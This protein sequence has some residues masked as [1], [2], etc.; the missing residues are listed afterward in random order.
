MSATYRTEV[1]RMVDATP[2]TVYAILRDYRDGHPSIL[3]KPEFQAL[4]VE[5]GGVGA[6]TLIRVDMKVG[7]RRQTFRMRVEEPEPGRILT[8]TDL[9]TGTF[10]RFTVLPLDGGKRARV[11]IATEWPRKRG[12]AG[13]IESRIVPAVTRKLYARELANLAALARTR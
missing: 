4:H 1:E 10:T 7:G 5:E 11:A 12:L 2:E 8:E 6:G 9:D 3:P 13:W